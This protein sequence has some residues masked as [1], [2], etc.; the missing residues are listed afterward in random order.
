MVNPFGVGAYAISFTGNQWSGSQQGGVTSLYLAPFDGVSISGPNGTAVDRA[1][2]NFQFDSQGRLTWGLALMPRSCCATSPAMQMPG[3]GT[4]VP[5]PALPISNLLA[6]VNGV[7]P[8]NSLA[9]KMTLGHTYFA[10]PDIAATCAVA[11]ARSDH[12]FPRMPRK[13]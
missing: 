13:R 6:A 4:L 1:A 7:G 11:E 10:V 5:L 9:N 12:L 8:G 3:V 2:G